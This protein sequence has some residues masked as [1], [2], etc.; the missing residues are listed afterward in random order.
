MVVKTHQSSKELVFDESAGVKAISIL[1]DRWF[2][3][4]TYHADEFSDMSY[5]MDL[6]NKQ[7]STLI[8][9]KLYPPST[10]KDAAVAM[11]VTR[12][13]MEAVSLAFKALPALNPNQP[14]QSRPAPM[15][16]MGRLWGS[17][18]MVP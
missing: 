1:V 6:K 2:V 14:I 17:I 13:A 11:C 3:Q 16:V 10:R 5:F 7:G 15:R 9:L 8:S 12:N 18:R 4:N